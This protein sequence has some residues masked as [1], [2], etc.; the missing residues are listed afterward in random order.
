ML[1]GK[2]VIVGITGSIAAYKAAFLVRLLMQQG[3]DVKVVMTP[4]AADFITPLSLS[5]LTGHTVHLQLQDQNTWNNHVELGIWADLMIVA[6]CTATTL[7][8][9]ASG[10]ADNLLLA[11]YLSL[12][13]PVMF[14]PAMDV[15]MWRH[16]AVQSNV[17][18][19]IARSHILVPVGNGKL[20]SGLEGEGRMA[21]PQEIV[22]AANAF[23][24][25][26]NQLKGLH[27]LLTS[28]PT[29]EPLDPVRFLTNRSSGK[30]G[31]ALASSL[32]KMGAEVTIVSGP[33]ADGLYPANAKVIRVETADQ[34]LKACLE[35][36]E[37]ADWCVF[38][39]AVAD[40]RPE[41]VYAEKLKKNHPEWT[42]RMVKNPD[43][44]R[45]ISA[46][47]KSHQRM[48]GFALETEN[49]REHAN[50]KLHTKNLDC[51]VLNSLRHPGAGFETDTNK[52]TIICND[53]TEVEIDLRRKSEVADGIVS[54]LISKY[55]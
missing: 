35:I 16:P 7:S 2:K 30:M 10:Q 53:Q 25:K 48:I 39:A 20:A 22:T 45:E 37:S 14:A 27:V 36:A 21:E 12:R 9:M 18:L 44:A 34:M 54:F 3:A 47:R 38:A 29:R 11:V 32:L 52:V 26:N 24:Y 6:P 43:I 28:G 23:F 33:V 46:G 19:L 41:E 49:E 50:Q 17:Q 51:I 8:K 42:L 5:S 31:A 4:S 13:C 40:Y 15:D 55:T 1:E